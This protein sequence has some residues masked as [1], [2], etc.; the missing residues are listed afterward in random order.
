MSPVSPWPACSSSTTTSDVV[1]AFA[2]LLRAEA[3]R[4]APRAPARRSL[5]GKVRRVQ[6]HGQCNPIHRT[7]LDSGQN[8]AVPKPAPAKPENAPE[9]NGPSV[10]A[11]APAT[12]P[13]ESKAAPAAVQGQAA[14][15]ALFA[16]RLPEN[17]AAMLCY[18][19][20]WVSGLGFLLADRRPFVRYHAAQ[21]VVVFAT[22]SLLMLVLGDFMLGSLMPQAGVI[23]LILHRVVALVWIVAALVL[24]LKAN[25]G[26]RCRVPI[27]ASFADRAARVKS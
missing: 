8:N 11:P 12:K 5:R 17:V 2:E 4:S 26:E 13:A 19:L 6:R 22:L 1:D 18:L 16:E 27:A 24:M 9:A 3:T 20:G 25:A 7:M 21:S 23:L 15:S 10:S 14:P